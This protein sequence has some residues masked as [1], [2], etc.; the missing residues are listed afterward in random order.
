MSDIRSSFRNDLEPRLLRL[1]VDHLRGKSA[2]SPAPQSPTNASR[3]ILAINRERV[4]V[5]L[6]EQH[7]LEVLN[8]SDRACILVDGRNLRDGDAP[9]LAAD[10]DVR[11]AFLGG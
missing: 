3:S 11:R 10:P 9:A 8:L 1:V 7:A 5:A 4:S 6:V 2:T